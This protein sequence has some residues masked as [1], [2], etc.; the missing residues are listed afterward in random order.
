MS[1][2]IIED[3]FKQVAFN[4]TDKAVHVGMYFE[5]TTFARRYD[6]HIPDCAEKT[7]A[8]QSLKLALMHFGSAIAKKDCYKNGPFSE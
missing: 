3:I 4:T 1:L 7:L 2:E 6:E 5:L 8:L